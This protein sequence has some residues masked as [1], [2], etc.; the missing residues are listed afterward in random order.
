MWGEVPIPCPAQVRTKFPQLSFFPLRVRIDLYHTRSHMETETHTKKAYRCQSCGVEFTR[1]SSLDRH[2][3]SKTACKGIRRAN[4][5]LAPSSIPG[6]QIVFHAGAGG[7][8][9]A[10]YDSIDPRVLRNSTC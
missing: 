8:S 5:A 9:G 4:S 7:S 3:K 1:Q 2:Q 6:E 10:P